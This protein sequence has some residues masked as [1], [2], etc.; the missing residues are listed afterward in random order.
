MKKVLFVVFVLVLI[1]A[2]AYAYDHSIYPNRASQGVQ[3]VTDNGGLIHGVTS[4]HEN[5]RNRNF[6]GAVRNIGTIYF[7]FKNRDLR[8]IA[9]VELETKV[10]NTLNE[11]PNLG[12]K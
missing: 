10:I 2:P 1:I 12:F 7:T 4:T 9:A 5:V 3:T 6:L 8:Q 11:T